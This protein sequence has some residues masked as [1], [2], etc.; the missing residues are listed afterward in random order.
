MLNVSEI[1]LD[2][3]TDALKLLPFLFLT[4]AAMEYME[5]K[6]GEKAK[7]TIEK[8]GR[9]GPAFGAVFGAFPQCGFSTAASNLFAGRII[10]RGTLIAVFLSTSDE[11]LP[12]LIS[13]QAGIG[14]IIKLLGIKVLIGIAAGFLV[15]LL[16]GR[17]RLV[18]MHGRYNHS[19][20]D[21]EGTEH[22]DIGHVCE[23]EHCRCEEG[24]IR[25]AVRHTIQIFL[26]IFLFSFALNLAISV[27]GEDFLANLILSKPVIGHL[28]AG[29]VGMI[30]NCAASVIITQLYLEGLMGLGMMMAGLLVGSGVGLLVLFR[31][32]DNKKENMEILF[33]LYVIGVLAGVLLDISGVA[34]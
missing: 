32:N 22:M 29:L 31:V 24:I 1:I 15:D 13:E 16:I 5:H 11:M 7:G 33:S 21:I 6:M 14:V 3:L 28:A 12:I 9:F 26:F 23:H 25:S 17:R 30:P 34:V 18:H 4:Y 2:A 10:T 20:Y 27:V 8:A 19:K